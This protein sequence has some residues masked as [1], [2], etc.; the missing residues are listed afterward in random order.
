MARDMDTW[1]GQRLHRIEEGKMSLGAVDSA[2]ARCFS[3]PAFMLQ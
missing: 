2:A 3:K 1:L